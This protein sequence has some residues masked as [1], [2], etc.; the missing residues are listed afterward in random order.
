MAEMEAQGLGIARL[1]LD[2]ATVHNHSGHLPD[3]VSD[4]TYQPDSGLSVIVLG[5]LDNS[6]PIWISRGLT[7]IAHGF[8]AQV[9]PM[10]KAIDIAPEI[11]A[12][13][14]GTYVLM[15]NLSLIVTVEGN[16]LVVEAT[17]QP[18]VRAY[19]KTETLFF[20]RTDE[21]K[22]EFVRGKDG[23]FNCIVHQGGQDIP[24]VRQ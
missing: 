6:S 12:Q 16:H 3:Y 10:P 7:T 9:V 13:Y 19:A 15:P 22:L 5:N 8:P 4:M 23:K 1:A 17:G 18:K 11:L 24:G 20:A 14:A 2:G 21:A